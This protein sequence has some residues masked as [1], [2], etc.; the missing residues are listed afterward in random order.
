MATTHTYTYC[1]RHNL[2]TLGNTLFLYPPIHFTE[3][4][5]RTPA[6]LLYDP[7]QSF[8]IMTHLRHNICSHILSCSFMMYSG[9]GMSLKIKKVFAYLL[10]VKVTK[11]WYIIIY[12]Y[13]TAAAAAAYRTLHKHK[14]I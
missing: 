14:S 5:N 4:F 12:Y 9:L 6:T 3:Q 10:Y 13:Q 2:L 8:N 11:W 7:P 1:K